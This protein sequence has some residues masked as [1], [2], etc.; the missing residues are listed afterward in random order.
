VG[1]APLW[2]KYLHPPGPYVLERTRGVEAPVRCGAQEIPGEERGGRSGRHPLLPAV[3]PP[4]LSD[5]VRLCPIRSARVLL[6]AVAQTLDILTFADVPHGTLCP[7]RRVPKP[8]TIQKYTFG[9]HA[10]HVK[11]CQSL[12]K[13]A[14]KREPDRPVQ[15]L[16]PGRYLAGRAKTA[17]AQQFLFNTIGVQWKSGDGVLTMRSVRVIIE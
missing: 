17:P 11:L 16:R 5:F 7:K 12:P 8:L 9:A 3:A 13:S 15:T 6:P 14:T 2:G 1:I 10:I 4:D